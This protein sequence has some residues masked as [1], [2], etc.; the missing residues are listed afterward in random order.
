MGDTGEAAITRDERSTVWSDLW[1]FWKAYARCAADYQS[2][3]LLSL[4][5]YLAVGLGALLAR[6][7]RAELLD[8]RQESRPSYWRPRRPLG[9]AVKRLERQF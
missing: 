5:Y 2:A 1:Q 7:T 6:I 3:V 9:H 4:V 8:T